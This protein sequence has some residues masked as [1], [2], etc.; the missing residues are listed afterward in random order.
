MYKNCRGPNSV[1]PGSEDLRECPFG[2]NPQQGR[3]APEI[4]ILEVQP[5]GAVLEYDPAHECARW[6]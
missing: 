2:L 5:G 1:G 3:G 4:D 6:M